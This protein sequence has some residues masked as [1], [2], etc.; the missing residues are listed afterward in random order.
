MMTAVAPRRSVINEML[1]ICP[2]GAWIDVDDLS[3]FMEAAGHTF[4]VTHDAWSLYIGE[5]HYGSLGYDGCHGWSILQ[6][7]Y[8]LC[9]LFEYAAALGI[10]DIAYI[11]PTGARHDYHQMWG[12]DELEFLSRYDGLTY[13]RHPARRLLHRIA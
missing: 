9:V 1:R 8:L 10:I 3:R 2:V 7:R 5:S 4:E 13:F 12:T 11:E 6:L